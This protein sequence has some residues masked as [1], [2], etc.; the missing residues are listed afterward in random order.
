[1]LCAGAHKAP[2]A[3]AWVTPKTDGSGMAGVVADVALSP[4]TRR[5]YVRIFKG[6][7]VE[8]HDVRMI[9]KQV[10]GSLECCIL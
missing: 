5:D 10:R 7:N 2:L 8:V 6:L 9:V 1:M 3:A 4:E